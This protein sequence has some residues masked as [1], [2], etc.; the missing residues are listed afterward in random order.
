M[1]HTKPCGLLSGLLLL[2][3]LRAAAQPSGLIPDRVYSTHIRSVQLY[4]PPYEA[5]YPL[6]RLGLR[7]QLVLEFDELIPEDQRESDFTAEFVHCDA[8][9]QP[10]NLLPLE[11]YEGFP[12]RLLSNFQRSAFTKVPYV[13]YQYAF[14][15]E[16]EAFKLSGNYLLLVY[17]G[18]DQEDVQFTQRFV[19]VENGAG[20]S[21]INTVSASLLRERIGQF[22]FE[23]NTG[24]L[25][26]FNPGQDLRVVLLQNF[27]WD[28]AYLPP[29]AR[30]AA[31]NRF[32]YQVQ[33]DAA[34][35]AGSEFR[36]MDLRS[37]RLYGPQVEEVVEM[38]EA[39][40][41]QLF[42]DKIRP[43]NTWGPRQDWNGSFRIEVQEWPDPDLNA[44]YVLCRFALE[45]PPLDGDVYVIGRF[46]H[47]LPANACLLTYQPRLQRY[48]G[49][50]SFKQ[51]IY[52]YCY[53]VKRP[54]QALPDETLTEGAPD[55]GEN[56]YTVFIY[57]RAPGDRSDRLIGYLPVNY[58]E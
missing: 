12:Q 1:M 34:F 23:V 5:S 37:T 16:G 48:E 11:F 47:W 44:D 56:F 20:A 10:D 6:L 49:D 25:R 36:W 14:P 55:G 21:L 53:A 8:N 43:F 28:R 50:C 27:R 42:T 4:K 35:R 13:H 2:L 45:S 26:I 7:E 38:P 24:G 18:N 54:G 19:V 3:A 41:M 29:V 30:F 51:G 15:A 39:F 17:R 57:Y 9:W 46:A 58:Q 33:T 22:W 40:E 31:E 32:Q 52:D